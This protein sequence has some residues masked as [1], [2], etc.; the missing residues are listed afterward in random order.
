MTK[1]DK[2]KEIIIEKVS[3]VFNKKGYY[4]TSLSDL[5]NITGL[6][7]GSIYGNFKNKE[8]VAVEAFN[9][10]M[11]IITKSFNM[12]INKYSNS[13]DRLLAYV[14]VYR[15]ENDKYIL[16]GGCPLLN[17][18]VESDDM[19]GV[20][21]ELSV[22]VVKKWKKNITKIINS[23]IKEREI[24]PKTDSENIAGLMISLFEGAGILTK[25]T[26][27]SSYMVNALN[28]VESLVLGIKV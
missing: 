10:N 12:E 27:D 21:K 17:T 25:A 23:G 9:Y 15:R 8:E 19:G 18:L 3:E 2:T 11:N 24:K 5:I 26:G 22:D 7:K 16:S 20:L 4:G 1:A 13:T 14:E 6:S 28:H